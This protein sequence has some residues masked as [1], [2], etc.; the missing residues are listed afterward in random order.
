MPNETMKQKL[1]LLLH[2]SGWNIFSN[3]VSQ[4]VEQIADFLLENGV[5]VPP[6]KIGDTIYKSIFLK[7]RTGFYV[8]HQVVGFH[9]GELPKLRGH[10]R[11]QYFIVWHKETN[12]IS[13]LN[14]E[15]IG[16]T[17]FFTKEEAEKALK[18]RC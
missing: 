14:F 4:N 15:Q 17:V 9:V 8:E 1:M 5:I 18:E 13:H 2:T 16:K 7:D 6:C 3:P 12:A 11:E 10:K